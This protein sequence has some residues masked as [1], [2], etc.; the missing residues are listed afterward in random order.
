MHDVGK[1]GI[2]DAILKKPGKLDKEEFE[3][4]KSH[5]RIGFEILS[6]SNRRTI[7]AAAIVAHQHHE[8]WDGNGYP[9]GLKGE[10]IHIYG[11]ILGLVDVFDALSNARLYK[12]AWDSDKVFQYIK[13]SRGTS[14]DP[15][16]VDLFLENYDEFLNICEKY[17]D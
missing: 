1:I 3:S 17:S 4:V 8:K 5:T 13:D 6:K 16:L 7:K 2:P 15:I 14:F 12:E 9:Q 10:N 11:R